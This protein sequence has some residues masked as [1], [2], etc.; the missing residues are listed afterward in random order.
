MDKA[1]KVHGYSVKINQ[2]ASNFMNKQ[3]SEVKHEV[4]HEDR[5]KIKTRNELV[6]R[7]TSSG[8]I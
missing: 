5:R 1:I 3:R 4:N 8:Q 2:K 6:C 7:G